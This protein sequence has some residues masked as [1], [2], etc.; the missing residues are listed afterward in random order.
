[1]KPSEAINYIRETFQDH[2]K[3]SEL[4]KSLPDEVFIEVLNAIEARLPYK[5]GPTGRSIIRFLFSGCIKFDRWT[6][7]T[8]YVLNPE[9]RFQFERFLNYLTLSTEDNTNTARF[10]ADKVKWDLF[11]LLNGTSDYDKLN[12]N[13][14]N[15][16]KSRLESIDIPKSTNKL[17]E[18]EEIFNG[19]QKIINAV[20]SKSLKTKITT[21][22]PVIPVITPVKINTQFKGMQLTVFFTPHFV[23]SGHNFVNVEEGAIA[24]PLTSSQW[25]NGHC[26]INIE[27]QGLY[28][29]ALPEKALIPGQESQI[30]NWPRV[31]VDTYEILDSI[32]W[33]LRQEEN[34]IGKWI[35]LPNDIAS[36]EW[37]LSTNQDRIDWVLQGPPGSVIQVMPKESAITE[38]KV[39]LENKIS[40]HK[41]CKIISDAFLGT[42]ECNEALFWLNVATE[43]LFEQRALDICNRKQLSFESLSGGKTYWERADD[44]IKQQFPELEGKIQWPESA[45]GVPSWFAKIRYLGKH[46]NLRASGKEIQAK[47]SIIS[48]HRNALFHGVKEGK[49]GLDD[50][51]EAL[52]AYS[53]LE[54]NFC[55][56]D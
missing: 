15:E 37:E 45:P 33:K 21:R 38:I 19:C 26:D 31:F 5:D 32:I 6:V 13:S 34:A 14:I 28:D 40:W 43:A 56:A 11:D 17:R 53:W 42:G 20:L 27:I 24:V 30:N 12:L 8:P 2:T 23:N 46:V 47:Y 36:I 35:L 18:F 25:Q 7:P 55:L 52:K 22:L 3:T 50:T 9:Y 44:V 49:V 39:N 51:E 48:K 16:I 4:G 41:R 10:L 29:P 1:M 54:D